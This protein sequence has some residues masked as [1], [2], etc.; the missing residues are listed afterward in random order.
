[1]YL[2]RIHCPAALAQGI[3]LFHLSALAKIIA[4]LCVAKASN[5]G[6]LNP[7][8]KAGAMKT[9]AINIIDDPNQIHTSNHLISINEAVP[10]VQPGYA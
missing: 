1:M 9:L 4:L 5:N 7:G 10:N 8:L 3:R 2:V 6:Y